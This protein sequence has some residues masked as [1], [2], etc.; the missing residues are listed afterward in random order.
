LCTGG[1]CQEGQGLVGDPCVD[2]AD[3]STSRC[4]EDGYCSSS[5]TSDDDCSGNA[6]CVETENGVRTCELAAGPF[7]ASC[8]SAD[9][10]V[11][12]VCIAEEGGP[13]VCS[14]ECGPNLPDC[15]AAWTCG[16]VDGESVCVPPAEV[17][18]CQCSAAGFPSRV[19]WGWGL[20]AVAIAAAARGR[21]RGKASKPDGR[22]SRGEMT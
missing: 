10:C 15:P 18:G 14:R 21:M 19:P 8:S 5:C 20:V 6:E 9:E 12:G 7:G 3:C 22:L 4:S 16:E 13:S 17:T 1:V 11:G 2:H